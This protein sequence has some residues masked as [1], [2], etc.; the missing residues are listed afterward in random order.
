MKVKIRLTL[1]NS[2]ITLIQQ[3]KKLCC[4]PYR[5]D[6]YITISNF[7]LLDNEHNLASINNII[8][9]IINTAVGIMIKIIN[10]E[11]DMINLV[12]SF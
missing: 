4:L 10:P 8:I 3:D 1:K 12:T 7:N 6:A 2:S 11:H 9:I 5:Q